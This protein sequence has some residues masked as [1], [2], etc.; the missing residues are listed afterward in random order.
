MRQLAW[1]P[2]LSSSGGSPNRPRTRATGVGHTSAG[3]GPSDPHLQ[4]HER[5]SRLRESRRTCTS[6]R[7][8]IASSSAHTS[9]RPSA[10]SPLSFQE[11]RHATIVKEDRTGVPIFSDP[12]VISVR[13]AVALR[14]ACRPAAAP[15]GYAA[16]SGAPRGP[17]SAQERYARFDPVWSWPL[18]SA[19]AEALGRGR[20]SGPA[21]RAKQAPM[22]SGPSDL[23]ATESGKAER[24]PLRALRWRIQGIVEAHATVVT[25]S[26]ARARP[27]ASWDLVSS[28]LSP[29]R[30]R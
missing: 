16:S 21:T 27:A 19:G 24:R 15:G 11:Y 3:R 29:L 10:R 28:A 17:S 23:S 6:A 5:G 9:S 25:P 13:G 2:A 1:G 14:A 26:P 4:K 12:G 20:A 22:H 8:R 18:L 30:A 7:A